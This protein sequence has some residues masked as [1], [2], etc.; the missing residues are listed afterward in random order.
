LGQR[1]VAVVAAYVIALASLLA[2]F[3][4]A[5]AA[6]NPP[7]SALCHAPLAAQPASTDQT[8]G[9]ICT[10]YS[11]CTGCLTMGAAVPLP[12]FVIGPPQL[13]FKRLDLPAHSVRLADAKANAHR[14]RGPPPAL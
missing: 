8:N 9:K 1:I 3:G 10:D 6:V 4:A 2:A 5:Q 7:D 14:S 13:A 11:C 12:D